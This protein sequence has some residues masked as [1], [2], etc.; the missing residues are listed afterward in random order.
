MDVEP[1]GLETCEPADDRDELLS[2]LIQMLQTLVEAEV[3]KIV[4]AE[5]VAQE[6]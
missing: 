5:F 6:H 4:G 3:V 2:D 1:L